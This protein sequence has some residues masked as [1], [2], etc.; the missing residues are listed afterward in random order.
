MS[1]KNITSNNLTIMKLYEISGNI[2]VALDF[3]QV[4]LWNLD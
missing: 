4:G 2:V 3:K 1:R